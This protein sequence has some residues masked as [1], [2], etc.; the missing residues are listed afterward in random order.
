MSDNQHQPFRYGT[1]NREMMGRWLQLAAEDDGPFW[2]LNLMR[3]RE[4][5]EY[6]DGRESSLTGREADDAYA[7][8]GPLEAIGAVPAFLGD[9]G[10]QAVGSPG[11]DRVGIV[12]YP[13]RAG[14]FAMQQ[15]EDFKEL[16]EHKEAG[17]EFTI[18]MSCLP[19]VGASRTT[20]SAATE[21]GALVLTVLREPGGIVH[22]EHPGVSPL[23]RFDVEG[24][25]VGDERSWTEARFDRV[26][27]EPA[28]DALKRAAAGA[29]DAVMVTVSPTFD[30]LLGSMVED[31]SAPGRVAG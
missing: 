18:V 28:H 10:H 9:V 31:T 24:V 19:A 25:I 4:R 26:D 1:P 3:Y 27:G 16:H 8:L 20:G 5:A 17:M 23:V 11:W 15:R 22:V 29:Q 2:A 13:S 12:R 6:A 30:H 7:P 21:A 14:F